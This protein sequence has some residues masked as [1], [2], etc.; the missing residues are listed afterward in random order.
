MNYFLHFLIS[1]FL[2][3]L[4]SFLYYFIANFNAKTYDTIYI[5]VRKIDTF[6][7]DVQLLFQLFQVLI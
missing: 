3:L 4:P 7:K 1:W 2:F 5:K 6:L